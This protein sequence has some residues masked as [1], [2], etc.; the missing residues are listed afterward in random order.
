M[1]ASPPRGFRIRPP[2]TCARCV[3]PYCPRRL[4]APLSGRVTVVH[5][6]AHPCRLGQTPRPGLP[7]LRGD[8]GGAV[9]IPP[10]PK[11]YLTRHYRTLLWRRGRPK[12][13]VAIARKLL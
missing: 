2:A 4:P 6:S 1:T 12:A 7:W 8:V 9:V 10:P 3:P 5:L 11:V 13:I